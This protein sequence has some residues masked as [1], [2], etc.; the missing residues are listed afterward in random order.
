MVT[1]LS[2]AVVRFGVVSVVPAPITADARVPPVSE[3]VPVPESVRV[4]PARV[5]VPPA[6]TRFSALVMLRTV[7]VPLNVMV[8]D[9][10]ARQCRGLPRRRPAVGKRPWLQFVK[11]CQF[12]LAPP[13]HVFVEKPV[14]RKTTSLPVPPT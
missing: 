5:R 11:S 10:P 4:P 2:V 8:I 13:I 14:V 9:G 6:M 1:P 3:K 12:P 7:A